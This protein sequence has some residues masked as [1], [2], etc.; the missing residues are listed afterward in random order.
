[1][2]YIPLCISKLILYVVKN[3]TNRNNSQILGDDSKKGKKKLICH[4][5][6]S[7]QLLLV[8]SYRMYIRFFSPLY[9]ITQNNKWSAKRWGERQNDCLRNR[10][11]LWWFH[12]SHSSI[13]LQIHRYIC[14]SRYIRYLHTNYLQN[15]IARL[16]TK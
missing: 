4:H 11:C 12:I 2:V 7:W 16:Y 3:F 8:L 13:S 6:F 9:A 10:F 1:M 5:W 14:L 15:N